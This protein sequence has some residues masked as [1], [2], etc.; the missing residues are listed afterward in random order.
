MPGQ[1]T[2]T[3]GVDQRKAG[4]AVLNQLNRER[5]ATGAVLPIG[6][7]VTLRSR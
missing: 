7:S 3:A 1:V 5:D 6:A 2:E 4:K